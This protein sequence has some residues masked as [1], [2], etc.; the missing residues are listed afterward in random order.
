C[1]AKGRSAI[2]L[3]TAAGRLL[4]RSIVELPAFDESASV[5]LSAG[6]VP[7]RTSHS[8]RREAVHQCRDRY[9]QLEPEARHPAVRVQRAVDEKGLLAIEDAP[10][11][12]LG[13]ALLIRPGFVRLDFQ[14]SL[15]LLQRLRLQI[16]ELTLH[17]LREVQ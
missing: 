7:A 13:L 16:I 1:S 11:P 2:S 14:H 12:R 10:H 4:D 5:T 8:G 6:P 17:P 15:Q 9:F 3:P